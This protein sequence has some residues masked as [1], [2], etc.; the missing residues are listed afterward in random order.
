VVGVSI[1]RPAAA[2]GAPRCRWWWVLLVLLLVPVVV[3][4]LVVGLVCCR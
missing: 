4:L 3:S 2:Q 1:T